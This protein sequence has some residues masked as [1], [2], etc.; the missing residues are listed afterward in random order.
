MKATSRLST[1]A[2]NWQ[3]VASSAVRW[4]QSRRRF[5]ESIHITSKEHM[6][7][8]DCFDGAKQ[9]AGEPQGESDGLGKPSEEDL[10]VVHPW[11]DGRLRDEAQN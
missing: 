1:A 5:S 10:P 2:E 11:V 3:K 6:S 4:A 7:G 8:V 9:R